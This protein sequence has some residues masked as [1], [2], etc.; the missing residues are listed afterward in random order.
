MKHIINSVLVW[1]LAG[2][3]FA[4]Q[5]KEMPEESGKTGFLVSLTDATEVSASRATPGELVESQGIKNTDFHL[6]VTNTSTHKVAYEGNVTEGVVSVTEGHYDLVAEYGENPVLALDAPY[7]RGDVKSVEVKGGEVTSISIPCKV[8]NSLLSVGYDDSKK[9]FD[10]IYSSYYVE[11]KTG[12]ESVDIRDVKQSAYFRSGSAIEVVFHGTLKEGGDE[13]SVFLD[14]SG[15]EA[16]PLQAGDHLKL[17]LSPE[18]DKYDIPLNIVGK[19]VTEATLA[20]AIPESWLPKPK[21]EAE[22]F[23]G[24]TLTFVETEVKLARLNLNLASALQD[25]KLKFQFEDGQFASSLQKKEYLLSEPDDKAAI[26][27]AL[28]ILLPSIGAESA[29]ID[30]SPLVSRL[31]TNDGTATNNSIEIDVKANDRW[32]SEVKE[33][34]VAPDLK[35]RLICNKPVFT[36]AVKPENCWSREFTVD[37]VQVSGNADAEKIKSDLVYQYFDGAEWVECATRDNV[38]GRTQQ[39]VQAAEDIA[40]K[41]YKVRA[42]YRGVIP[43]DEA[44]AVLETP[45]QLPNSNMEEWH[46]AGVAR[47]I[48][49][50]YPYSSDAESFWNTNNSYTTRYV[51]S[52]AFNAGSEA[53]NCFP[54]VS[55]VP[56]RDGGKAAELRNTAAG[57]GNTKFIGHTEL[58]MNKVAGELFVGDI[59][60]ITGG[61]AAQ[62]NGDH[63]EIIKGK[64]F[65]SRPTALHFYYK[66]VPHNDD[67]WRVNIELLD[68]D[69]QTIISE[70]ISSSVAANDYEGMTVPLDYI[71]E[72][73][74]SKCKYIYII[75]SST[76]NIGSSLPYGTI[77]YILWRDGDQLKYSDTYIGSILTID[78]IS[79]IYDK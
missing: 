20:E 21:I 36:V 23:D 42:L 17:T 45:V 71:S 67:T 52:A 76:V 54:A 11:V 60:V 10:D 51:S 26:E 50:Y 6:T 73:T 70:S 38:T 35:Y 39:F 77:D 61:T 40:A 29:S 31:Q 72:E 2:M 62:P 22:G 46:T 48:I 18:S 8:A 59:K 9:S 79:L 16:F 53:Y 63:Y 43:S 68:A 37:E 5:E 28:G 57:R 65:E 32:S 34:E 14:L 12:E 49:T 4:C 3:L 24:N 41:T 27:N 15:I 78:D 19:E 74:Y 64:S 56:G 33:G 66:Y 55:Y 47:S 13:R 44:E 25:M 75:F 1:C 30:L 58:D 69:R 7:F